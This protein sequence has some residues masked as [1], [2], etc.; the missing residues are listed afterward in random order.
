MRILH[1]CSDYSKQKLYSELLLHLSNHDISQLIYVPVRSKKE[2]GSY[3]VSNY[4]NIKIQYSLILK[5]FHRLFF[6]KKIQTVFS[7]VLKKIDP[8]NFDLTHAH[9]LF[10]DGAVALEIYKKFKI[11]YIVCV[12]NTDV[13]YFFKYYKH[14]KSY[15][16]EILSNARKII[17]ITPSYRDV[18]G[19]K[20]VY[21]S[22]KESFENKCIILPNGLNEYWFS[23]NQSNLQKKR[24]ETIKLLYVGDFTPNKNVESIIDSAIKLHH[25]GLT[26]SLTLVGGGGK[27]CER[28]SKK[29]ASTS[30]IPIS[31]LGSINDREKLKKIYQEHDI[32]I[33]PS[34][35][36]T[37]GIVY[38]EAISQGV[39][40]IYTKNQGV[41]GYYLED[42][43]PGLP[44]NPK[45]IGDIAEAIKVVWNN[46]EKY[47]ANALDVAEQFRWNLIAKELS[48]I[49][50]SNIHE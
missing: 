1:I 12:R 8:K 2:M 25:E 42:K 37:F 27:G 7:N 49:Y 39:P 9:F 31:F 44:I 5:T 43:R 4:S 28:T 50:K 21:P 20:Y 32:F 14:L 46:L 30:D 3:D 47:S 19:E 38:I 45:D 34:Y 16:N 22:L 35:R 15:G 13:N 41:D 10:S 33:M 17:F 48:N 18:V 36:E 11:P 23:N 26:V 6:K 24:F 40:I 29:I